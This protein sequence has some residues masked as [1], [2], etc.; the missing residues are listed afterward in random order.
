MGTDRLR[1]AVSSPS[2][3]PEFVSRNGKPEGSG[4]R[5]SIF[6][7]PMIDRIGVVGP[8]DSMA[9]RYQVPLDAVLETLR[10]AGYRIEGG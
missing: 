10:Q 2:V 3:V 6:V 7:D 9:E 4:N 1:K 5:C 8:G